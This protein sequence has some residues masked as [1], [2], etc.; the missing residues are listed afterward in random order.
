MLT[1]IL[2]FCLYLVSSKNREEGKN[3]RKNDD[4]I[5]D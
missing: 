5:K 4:T 3:R 1:N 2:I